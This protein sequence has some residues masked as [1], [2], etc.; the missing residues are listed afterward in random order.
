M[1]LAAGPPLTARNFAFPAGDSDG[2]LPC[3]PPPAFPR[4]GPADRERAQRGGRLAGGGLRRVFRAAGGGGGGPAGGEQRG[5]GE[6]AAGQGGGAGRG[7][8]G[9]GAAGVAEFAS[10]FRGAHGLPEPAGRGGG[11]QGGEAERGGR[12]HAGPRPQRP[13]QRP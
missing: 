9:E 6:E 2:P 7:G 11:G 5:E 4:A 12:A 1:S 10:D 8:D 3:T 13:R